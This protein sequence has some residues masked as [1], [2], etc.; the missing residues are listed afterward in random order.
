MLAAFTAI[1]VYSEHCFEWEQ[2]FNHSLSL[3]YLFL[4]M[5]AISILELAATSG[6]CW[7]FQ[8]PNLP[9]SNAFVNA[10][11]LKLAQYIKTI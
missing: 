11:E 5:A 9:F 4:D 7:I 8:A 2:V 1:A 3:P 6:S 10:I